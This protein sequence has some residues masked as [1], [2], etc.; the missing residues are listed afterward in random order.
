M[1]F[2][3]YSLAINKLLKQYLSNVQAEKSLFTYQTEQAELIKQMENQS[4][5]V[6]DKFVVA[7]VSIAFIH[8]LYTKYLNLRY[9]R[10]EEKGLMDP[11]K[12]TW[13]ETQKMVQDWSSA[14]ERLTAALVNNG[15][16]TSIRC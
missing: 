2:R 7:L 12:I 15:N 16:P 14:R 8:G 6:S 3:L 4:L 11:T 13:G 5:P 1:H 9:F 10:A